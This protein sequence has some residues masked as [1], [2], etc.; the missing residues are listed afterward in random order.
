MSHGRTDRVVD[1]E[2]GRTL[3]TPVA[4]MPP[5]GCCVGRPDC[6]VVYELE[7]E[8]ARIASDGVLPFT[9]V[10]ATPS[11]CNIPGELKSCRN[12]IQDPSSNCIQQTISIISF[13]SLFP[14]PESM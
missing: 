4:V 14:N 9:E 7:V 8:G 6:C 13:L 5:L 1:D 2:V 12:L 11:L 3:F 10:L